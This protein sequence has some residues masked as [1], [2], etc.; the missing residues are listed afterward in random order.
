MLV[1]VNSG[2][3]DRERCCAHGHTQATTR[4]HAHK[5]TPPDAGPASPAMPR[6]TG[7]SG[8]GNTRSR[9]S[10]AG[11]QELGSGELPKPP[12]S[13][14]ILI[15]TLWK[16]RSPSSST[17]ML[18]VDLANAR[19]PGSAAAEGGQDKGRSPQTEPSGGC[20]RSP[21]RCGPRS[22]RVHRLAPFHWQSSGAGLW[23][24][25][26]ARAPIFIG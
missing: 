11:H 26:S 22:A 20:P 15:L 17:A 12:R 23:P 25:S 3:W 2:A 21:A 24:P 13:S 5:Q 8:R 16:T 18:L 9:S 1:H 7:Q 6:R 4:A 19:G 14:P 10:R